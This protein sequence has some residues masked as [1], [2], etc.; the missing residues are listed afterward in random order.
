MVPARDS[1]EA[2][3]LSKGAVSQWMKRACEGGVE[4]LKR[5]PA[6][7]ALPRLSEEQRAKVPEL[8]ERGAEAHGFRGE[9]W[10][11]ERVAIVIRKE[12]WGELSSGSRESFAQGFEAE[13]AEAAAPG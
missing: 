3:G 4:A 13:L 8:L 7:G 9:A 2:L 1:P 10:M 12:F 5:Q 11:C 6:P